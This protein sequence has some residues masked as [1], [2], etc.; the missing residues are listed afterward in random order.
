MGLIA[1]G[2]SQTE[3]L[4]VRNTGTVPVSFA[5]VE[6]G[7]GCSRDDSSCGLVFIRNPQLTLITFECIVETESRAG[8]FFSGLTF[9]TFVVISPE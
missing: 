2:T 8:V 9:G 5:A 3:E 6:V 7:G 1:V 4:R